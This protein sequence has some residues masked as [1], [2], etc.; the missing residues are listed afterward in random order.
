MLFRSQDWPVP[1]TVKQTRGFLG[2]GNF[3]RRF[4]QGF[5]NLAKPL[6]DL[7]KKDKKFEWTDDCQKAFNELKKRFTEE[8]VL[9]MPDQTKPFQIETDA[10]KYATGAVLTQ[11]DSNGNRHPISFISKTFSLT[12]CNYEIYDR[13]LLVIIRALMEWRHYIQG[14]PHTTTVLSDHKNLTYYREAQK[15]NR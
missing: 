13:E 14:S 8:P 15:L 9:M 3:Y 10:S 6:N 7:L 4:I 12:E 11:L 5:S 2:F 1:T